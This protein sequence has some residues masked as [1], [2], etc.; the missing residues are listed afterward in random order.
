MV[1][2]TLGSDLETQIRNL[3]AILDGY[4][5]LGGHHLNVNV[6]NKETLEDAIAHP[7][8]YPSLTVR[9]SGYAV[10][11]NKLSDEQKREILMRT[12]HC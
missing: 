8:H 11:F 4:F 7:E 5:S 12:F 1:P 2:K 6:L 9:I 3:V 10:L